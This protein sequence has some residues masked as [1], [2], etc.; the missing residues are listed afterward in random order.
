MG[1]IYRIAVGGG[2]SFSERNCVFQ[3]LLA[4][5]KQAAEKNLVVLRRRRPGRPEAK[6][7]GYQPLVL[8]GFFVGLKP[9]A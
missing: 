8:A 7:S 5:L 4:V 1:G 9:H 2:I 6:A 3:F